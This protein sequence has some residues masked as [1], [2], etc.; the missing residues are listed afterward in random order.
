[1]TISQ[2]LSQSGI[3]TLLGISVVFV[4]LIIMILAMTL[5]HA[6][7]HLFKLDSDPVVSSPSSAPTKA[8]EADNNAVVAAIATAI[9]DKVLKS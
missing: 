5:L 1:M 6:V 3:L 2:M 4:F 9:H 7:L 8:P